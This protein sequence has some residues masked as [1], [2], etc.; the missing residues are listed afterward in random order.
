MSK[1][2][3]GQIQGERVV[4]TKYLAAHVPQYNAWMQDP[5]LQEMTASEPLSLEE[6]LDLQEDWEAD[7]KKWIFIVLDKTDSLKMVGDVNLFLHPYL[8]PHEAEL[9]VMIAE[10]SAR[11]KGLASEAISLMMGF[12][13]QHLTITRFIVKILSHNGP[14][15]AMFQKMGFK[16]CEYVEAFDEIT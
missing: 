16:H 9:L 15:I 13:R 6:E 1:E 3:V 12:A 10:P 2:E 4:L 14:S 5:A 8:Q 7:P 11:R